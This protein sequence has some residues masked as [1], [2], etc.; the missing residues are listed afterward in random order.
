VIKD[1][2]L[3][4]L[5][6]RSPQG[7]LQQ[8]AGGGLLR[9]APDRDAAPRRNTPLWHVSRVATNVREQELRNYLGS[10][11]FPAIMATTSIATFSGGEKRV[12]RSR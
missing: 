12:W 7:D 5:H 3:C 1:H 9:A 6:R 10:F 4:E 11:A 8:G 2:P